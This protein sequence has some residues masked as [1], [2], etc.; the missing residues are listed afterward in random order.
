MEYAE[1]NNVLILSPQPLN[2][3]TNLWHGTKNTFKSCPHSLSHC[4][5]FRRDCAASFVRF[6]LKRQPPLV[7]NPVTVVLVFFFPL[8]LIADFQRRQNCSVSNSSSGNI[9]RL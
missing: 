2:P 3:Q 8:A 7:S 1:D 6:R 5:L 9:Y 4:F